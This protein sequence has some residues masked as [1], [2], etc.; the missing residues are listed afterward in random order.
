[1]IYDTISVFRGSHIDASTPYLPRERPSS[2]FTPGHS[3][4]DAAYDHNFRERPASLSFP[5]EPPYSPSS[6]LS[7]TLLSSDPL[8]LPHVAS[9]PPPRSNRER[10]ISI[11]VPSQHGL[12]LILPISLAPAIPQPRALALIRLD[13]V[14]FLFHFQP[15]TS[16]PLMETLDRDISLHS[17]RSKAK[18]FALCS[19]QS[20]AA[21]D[22]RET[23]L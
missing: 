22:H 16:L 14:L 7:S 1:V 15:T 5:P 8:H 2:S 10:P 11:S 21:H 17:K 13:R 9:T 12:S 4:S 23:P 20:R 19:P 18:V 3:P 6:S